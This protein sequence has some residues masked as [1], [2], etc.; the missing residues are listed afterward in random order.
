MFTRI[1]V[2][3]FIISISLSSSCQG[4]DKPSTVD[5]ERNNSAVALMG[6]FNFKDAH[7]L[8]R[9]LTKEFPENKE[10]Q[11]NMAI[12]LFNRQLKGDEKSALAILQQ[13]LKDDPTNLRAKYCSALL[14]LHEGELE[15]A[16]GYFRS[17]LTT[18]PS[19]AVLLYFIGET[20]MQLNLYQEAQQFFARAIAA[21]PY[22]SSGYYGSIMSL[23]QM[24]QLDEAKDM[25]NFYKKMKNNPRSRVAAF[26]YS[27]MGELAKVTVLG[28]M[29][30]KSTLPAGN[31][32]QKRKPISMMNAMSFQ[33]DDNTRRTDITVADING[34]NRLDIFLPSAD[35]SSRNTL[36]FGTEDISTFNPVTDHP[37]AKVIGVNS[38]LWGDIN[39]DGL[40]DAYFLCKKD[41]QLFLQSSAHSWTNVTEKSGVAGKSHNTIAGALFDADHDG[42]LDIYTIN[43]NGKNE[44]FNNNRDGSFRTLAEEKHI[45]G[46]SGSV[47]I[48]VQDLDGDRD[49]DIIVI[50]KSAPHQVYL[51]DRLWNYTQNTGFENLVLQDITAI[52]AGDIDSNG[53]IELYTLDGKGKLYRWTRKDNLF[54]KTIIFDIN[55]PV[56]WEN[57]RIQLADFDGNGT[58][59][60]LLSSK[61]TLSVLSSDDSGMSVLYKEKLNSDLPS[62]SL[63]N[64]AKG[65]AIV[66]KE[67][68]GS[69]AIFQPG[70]ARFEFSLINVTGRKNKEANLRTNS[71]G[72]GT[73]LLVRVGS[74]WTALDTF[75]NGM[76]N[77]QS[78]QPLAVGLG[79]NDFIDFIQLDWP[80]GV[81]Q[82]EMV[83]AP[84]VLHTIAETQRQM[85][86]CPVLFAW[87]GTKFDF[88]SDL[89]GVGGIG[90]AVGPGIYAESRPWEHF[91]LPNRFA[92][93]KNGRIM[94][95]MTEPME[96]V[97]YLDSVEMHAY[98]LPPSWSMVMDERMA[99]LDPQPTGQPLFYKDSLYPVQAIN[100][101]G[102][103]VTDTILHNDLK[104]APVGT[105]DRRFIGLLEDFHT[106][107]LSFS[108]PIRSDTAIPVL[109][110]DGWVEYPYSQTSFAAWQAGVE[111]VAPSIEIKGNNGEWKV[112]L[113]QFGYPAGMPRQMAVPL[114]NL[115]A[116]TKEIRITTNQEIY[117]DRLFIAFSEPCLNMKKQKLPLHKAVLEDI[118][119]PQRMDF[120][121]R[122]PYYD[123]SNRNTNWDSRLLEGNY[124]RFGDVL[125]LLG[126]K[127]DA[128][129]ILGPGE[130]IHMEFDAPLPPLDKGWERHFVLSS[131]GWCKDMDLFTNTG[132][133]VAPLP[134]NP[135]RDE[136]I[137]LHSKYNYRYLAGRR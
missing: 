118:G 70:P 57:S 47:A 114:N 128:L 127:D 68:K 39:D 40:L 20:Y 13:I 15:L 87:D 104:A 113:E 71:S 25:V 72:I 112:F 17:V 69:L 5:V 51:N 62:L 93:L 52:T 73:S 84:N 126:K 27:K 33:S 96:E 42:D 9:Q 122:R 120:D 60:I 64:T 110:A 103:D 98:D 55:Q 34:D 48:L 16:L 102:Q 86:S 88:V 129:T 46:D 94:L 28:G 105:L 89:L 22:L 29:G 8:F 50:N 124:T 61:S 116:G 43:L 1:L 136:V 111:F 91:L 79:G 2:S 58:L 77:G 121:Q 101:R 100:D 135:D 14:L 74:R 45:A 26:K 78:A 18:T 134:G 85:S 131:Y 82:T 23:R 130:G 24:G 59:E 109:V 54:V 41:N 106:L 56:S 53:E 63:M 81:F 7:V 137:R 10:L 117:W 36:L 19:D 37:L 99:I 4:K 132:D 49:A 75:S 123:Y 108:E 119:F 83:L 12:A 80:D 90:Y 32:F 133:T 31:L 30:K 76:S 97:E 115:P 92:N 11:V 6:Q 44:L 95:K 35:E 65:P 67:S 107:T 125:E 38:V 3:F 21:D 66:V